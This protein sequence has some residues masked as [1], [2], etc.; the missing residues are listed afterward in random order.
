MSNKKRTK[1]VI[2]TPS[3][4]EKPKVNIDINRILGWVKKYANP[5][6]VSALVREE[7][8]TLKQSLS[9]IL[10]SQLLNQVALVI[11][12][13]IG[14]L[15]AAPQTFTDYPLA[16]NIA[17][18]LLQALVAAIA[19]T[20]IFY[21]MSGV[22]Y[23]ITKLLGG[24]S[25]FGF[26]TYLL[27]VLNLCIVVIT[28]PLMLFAFVPLISPLI[29]IVLLVMSAYSFYPIFQVVRHTNNFSKLRAGCAVA[30]LFLVSMVLLLVLTALLAPF[31]V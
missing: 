20:A 4:V 31:L 17:L 30:L 29:Q 7:N 16:Y 19:S 1:K 23:L 9:I 24:K 27:S 8:G 18:A 13:F 25:N 22:L 26:Q 15:F 2:D 11:A 5:W 12:F 3:V 10:F 14:A 28:S 6:E 21:F